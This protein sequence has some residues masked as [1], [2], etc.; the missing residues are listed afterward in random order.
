M[1]KDFSAEIELFIVSPSKIVLSKV[2]G[3][4][5]IWKCRYDNTER[6]SFC[7]EKGSD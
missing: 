2:S 6:V 4:F 1:N 7:E 5:F 3:V